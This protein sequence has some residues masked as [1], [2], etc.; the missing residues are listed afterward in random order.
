[1]ETTT[2]VLSKDDFRQF[3]INVDKLTE[4]GYDM[5]H[6]VEALDDGQFKVRV[7]GDHD[8]DALDTLMW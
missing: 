6:E 5:P 7:F 4:Q 1:M 3:T 8:W 2:V